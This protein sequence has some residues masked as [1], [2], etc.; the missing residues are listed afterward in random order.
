MCRTDATVFSIPS[1][2]HLTINSKNTPYGNFV[3]FP[4]FS[5]R[6]PLKL[7]NARAARLDLEQH[8]ETIF[9]KDLEEMVANGQLMTKFY[10]LKKINM[11]TNMGS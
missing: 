5:P 3:I 10:M 1:Y 6:S 8:R 9:D 7:R 2:L 11:H 4:T